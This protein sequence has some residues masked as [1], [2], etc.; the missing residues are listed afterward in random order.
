[1]Y[2][3]PRRTSTIS[4]STIASSFPTT[5]F[6]TAEGTARLQSGAK[7]YAETIGAMHLRTSGPWGPG[8][9]RTL[10]NQATRGPAETMAHALRADCVGFL[11]CLMQCM[12]SNR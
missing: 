5:T 6:A 8:R 7:T 2:I 3:G 9:I 1:M 12:L 4:R 10:E 11:P